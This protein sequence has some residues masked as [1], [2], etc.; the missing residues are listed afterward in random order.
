MEF[1]RF[2]R[3][4]AYR[5]LNFHRCWY[6]IRPRDSAELG[7]SARWIKAG[8][9]RTSLFHRLRAYK[10]YWPSGIEV[11]AVAGIRQPEEGHA[12]EDEAIAKVEKFVLR[13]VKR[14]RAGVESLR[15]DQAD[16]AIKAVRSHPLVF[17]VWE[18][19]KEARWTP[20][21]QSTDNSTSE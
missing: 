1:S 21:N 15:W 4:E 5:K 14:I 2:Q 9:S 7:I 18:S 11:I 8:I 16:E 20:A 17:Y 10:T 3:T 13:K 12:A 19:S 6:L